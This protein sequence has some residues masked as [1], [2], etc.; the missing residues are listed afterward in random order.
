MSVHAGDWIAL[1]DGRIAE[2]L[3][4]TGD[5]TVVVRVGQSVPVALPPW[6]PLPTLATDRVA[7]PGVS[8]GL[9]WVGEG[10][11]VPPVPAGPPILCDPARAEKVKEIR[12]AI[13]EAMRIAKANPGREVIFDMPQDPPQE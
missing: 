10:V 2:V 4:V 9:G 12:E 1:E 6:P 3:E 8:F 13:R 5:G 11:P 7:P